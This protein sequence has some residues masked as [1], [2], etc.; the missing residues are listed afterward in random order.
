MYHIQCVRFF[1]LLIS[2]SASLKSSFC[3]CRNRPK[4]YG[5]S[6]LRDSIELAILV[7]AAASG[8]EYGQLNRVSQRGR[9]V[10]F[11]PIPASAKGR[12]QRGTL[13]NQEREKA[14]TLDVVHFPAIRWAGLQLDRE[15]LLGQEHR[16]GACVPGTPC[17]R[18]EA[19]GVR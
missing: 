2:E 16:G 5:S 14:H 11:G 19:A 6:A 7:S 8:N 9:P 12:F 17:A 1:P 3:A 18:T 10:Q 4:L 15:A 13:G